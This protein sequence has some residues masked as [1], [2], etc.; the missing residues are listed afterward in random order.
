MSAQQRAF[1]YLDILEKTEIVTLIFVD[2]IKA[3]KKMKTIK[4]TSRSNIKSRFPFA[5]SFSKMNETA[6][7]ESIVSASYK[8]KLVIANFAPIRPFIIESWKFDKIL[9]P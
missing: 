2:S 7:H 4:R 3:G 1:F 5:N 8:M 6:K 9:F